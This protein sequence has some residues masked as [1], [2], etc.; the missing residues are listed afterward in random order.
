MA[1]TTGGGL[2]QAPTVKKNLNLQRIGTTGTDIISGFITE[3]QL[4]EMSTPYE[5]AMVMDKMRRS[6][7]TV[8]TLLRGL[9]LPLKRALYSVEP[10]GQD[11]LD[12]ET[13]EFVKHALFTAPSK[14]W[15]TFM[16][17]ALRL[18]QFGNTAFEMVHKV[19][20]WTYT[21]AAE[22]GDTGTPEEQP[23]PGMI[24]WDRFAFLGPKTIRRWFVSPQDKV[25]GIEQMG[26]YQDG[27]K[28]WFKPAV[29]IDGDF[30]MLFAID[31]MGNNFEGTPI[32]RAGYR[33]YKAL[34]VLQKIQL[35][36]CNRMAIG[37]PVIN[38]PEGVTDDERDAARAVVRGY[39]AGE[40]PGM[41][42][43]PGWL[44]NILEGKMNEHLVKDAIEFHRAQILMLGLMQ[45]LSHGLG[46][47]SGNRAMS[48]SQ[49][50][51][52][53]QLLWATGKH[54]AETI[55]AQ[56]K[57]LLDLN[58]SGLKRYP[59]VKLTQLVDKDVQAAVDSVNACLTAGSIVAYPAL[60]DHMVEQLDLPPRPKDQQIPPPAPVA[61]DPAATAQ[62]KKDAEQPGLSGHDHGALKLSARGAEPRHGAEYWNAVKK[63]LVAQEKAFQKDAKPILD[64][65]RKE[66]LPQLQQAIDARSVH[67]L[68][69]V[70]LPK[71]VEFQHLVSLHL[72]RVA[73]LGQEQVTTELK[74]RPADPALVMAW[75]DARGTLMAEAHEASFR[76]QV[77]G[78]LMDAITEQ[79][80]K[81]NT[82]QTLSTA[83]AAQA[84][85][86]TYSRVLAAAQ[87]VIRG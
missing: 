30:L 2:R 86:S 23:R 62:E 42:L 41:V 46:G 58:Y 76:S 55:T 80:L 29:V 28:T 25:L 75:A 39:G 18:F 33:D 64:A 81:A 19:E 7:S 50:D 44:V 47:Q 78:G 26:Y 22:E 51:L 52:F 27:A 70:R 68:A 14:P 21:P 67:Q 32:T 74:G 37:T 48:G 43:P 34:E 69:A 9:E 24:V 5:R 11:P 13:A 15:S 3:E 20:D 10:A 57:R 56:A 38:E 84:R 83:F 79:R 87:D 16:A 1:K 82:L 8:A 35:R 85:T 31:Q 6:D 66:V 60:S 40:E 63:V 65:Q 45:F 12:L 72:A 61:P 73:T 49:I 77:V 71:M 36:G 17:E 53:M 59:E 4:P 54:I